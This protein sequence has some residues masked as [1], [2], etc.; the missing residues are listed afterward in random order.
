MLEEKITFTVA[1]T[2][3]II[4]NGGCCSVVGIGENL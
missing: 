2:S 4:V 1:N 3:L